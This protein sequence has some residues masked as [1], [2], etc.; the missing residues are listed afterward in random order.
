MSDD[1]EGWMPRLSPLEYAL[2]MIT[3]VIFVIASV[4]VIRGLNV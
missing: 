3:L 4:L 2:L 1:D